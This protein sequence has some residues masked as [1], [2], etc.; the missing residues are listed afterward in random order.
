MIQQTTTL[1]Q[2][3]PDLSEGF[4]IRHDGHP[5]VVI[6]G[7]LTIGRTIQSD[8]VLKDP[9]VSLE[10]CRVEKRPGGY[11]IRDLKS[12]N[13]VFI[14]GIKVT[15][16]Q[17]LNGSQIQI[18]NTS[19][20]FQTIR[21]ESPLDNLPLRSKNPEWLKQLRSIRQLSQTS[22]PVFLQGESGT[23][24]EVIAHLIHDQ[25]SR[26]AKP[27]ISVNCSA[28]TET[29]VE[30]ELFGHVRGSFTGATSD[31]KGAFE[32]ARGGT[33]FLDEIG[34]LPLTLQPKLLRALEN[35]EIK[36]VGSDKV[37]ETDVRIISA[38]HKMLDRLVAEKQFR[39]D[40]YFRIHV[41]TLTL[42]PLRERLEDF[43]DLVYSFCRDNR[44]RFSVA[45]IEA[46]KRHSWPGNIRELKNVVAR[47]KAIFPD[48]YIQPDHVDQLID[49]PFDYFSSRSEM[50]RPQDLLI[51]GLD[52]DIKSGSVLKEIEKEIIK[53][54]LQANG[55][56]QRRT[57]TEL[58]IPKSTLHDRIRAYNIEV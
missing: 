39:A 8:L 9:H 44:I 6:D 42:P 41:V 37:I 36:P 19:F 17:L 53:T 22:L 40:L 12:T 16:A 18:G 45:A 49:K 23:G 13:G 21:A 29:L 58:G 5:P 55:G 33:L 57:A 3:P 46:L 54:R 15:E 10:H 47:A 7:A 11:F 48:T 32:A 1:S 14:N 20:E 52:S 34:D 24:K 2:L 43:D 26:S 27:F 50:P 51:P 28:L 38:T 25:S 35:R 31:R 56:N 30:S 4:L